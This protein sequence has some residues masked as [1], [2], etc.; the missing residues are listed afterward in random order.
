MAGGTEP[1]FNPNAKAQEGTD[2]QVMTTE[3]GM[4]STEGGRS[5][6][7]YVKE[8]ENTGDAKVD[9]IQIGG[10]KHLNGDGTADI[11]SIVIVNDDT[12]EVYRYTRDLHTGKKDRK[13]KE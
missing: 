2:V 4:T 9:S 10:Y 6:G 12:I 1:T 5:S 8:V 7:Y 13:I 3:G 11:G